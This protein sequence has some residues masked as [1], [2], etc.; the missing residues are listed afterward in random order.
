MA[1]AST[2][3][4][5]RSA[6]DSPWILD[7]WR[8]LLLIVATPLCVL[9][10][11]SLAKLHWSGD[12]ITNFA[13][14]SAIG[15][16]LPGIM[17]AYCDRELFARFRARFLIAPVVLIWAAWT[18]TIWEFKGIVLVAAIW[19]WWHYM[20]QAYGFMRIY[21]AKV[22]S[23]SP[24]TRWLDKALCVTWF[25]APVLLARNALPVFLDLFYKCGGP[26]IPATVIT[27]VRTAAIGLTCLV[28][29]LFVLHTLFLYCSGRAS[30][31]VKLMLMFSTFGFYWY[32]LATVENVLVAYALF[33]LFHDVQYLTIV[34]VFNCGRA[35][36][37]AQVGGFTRFLFRKRGW[38]IVL[39]VALVYAYGSLDYSVKGISNGLLKQTLLGVFLASTLL[40]YYYDGF[41]WKL[42]EGSTR[43][44]LGLQAGP[45]PPRSGMRMGATWKHAAGWAGLVVLVSGLNYLQLHNA[46]SVAARWNSIAAVVPDNALVHFNLATAL[47]ANGDLPAAINE[48]RRALAIHPRYDKAHFNLAGLLSRA[49]NS[50]EAMAHYIRATELR[51]H[52]GSAYNNLGSLQLQQSQF[53]AAIGAFE[54]ALACEPGNVGFAQNLSLARFYLGQ[55]RELAGDLVG[56]V[57]QYREAIRRPPQDPHLRRQIEESLSRLNGA[58]PDKPAEH[59]RQPGGRTKSDT[60]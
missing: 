18:A 12:E 42:R 55:Q 3:T 41:I 53:Q 32:S 37:D 8:D 40:H 29:A 23:F 9:F 22:G 31:S 57:A 19:G 46:T 6:Q 35:E 34:W 51:P 59:V 5:I 20:A 14:V 58:V 43:Q 49:G 13:L 26:I 1:I 39:Y 56:A 54:R 33:E 44:P 36:R 38:L 17:R 16:H 11:I 30:S 21:D 60:T 47:E 27:A 25:A 15:H 28:T 45:Q 10:G 4:P 50:A 52:Y 7:S 48:Y 24:V 2:Q